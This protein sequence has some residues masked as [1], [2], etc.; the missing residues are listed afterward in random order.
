LN[1]G[2]DYVISVKLYYYADSFVALHKAYYHYVHYNLSK[3]SY[4]RIRSLKDHIKVV[5]EVERFL[6]EKGLLKDNY[7]CQLNLRKFNIKSN[8]LTKQ[9]LDYTLYKET[10]PELNG[11]W[12]YFNYSLSEKIKFWLAEKNLY[13][14]LRFIQK[15]IY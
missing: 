1:I 9:T 2:E 10:F 12:R 11:L 13:L 14:I 8:F 4:Q 7:V 6:S 15:Y 3:L 5:E